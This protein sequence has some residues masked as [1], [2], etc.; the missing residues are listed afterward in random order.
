M[1]PRLFPVFVAPSLKKSRQR[2]F[3]AAAM[4]AV[5]TLAASPFA[6]ALTV[7]WDGGAGGTG[8]DIGT[9][10]NWAGD[11]LPSVVTP[12][13]A[14]WNGTATG[15]LSLVYS[16]AVFAG[17][18]GN[19]GINLN[20]TS[21]QT[22]ALNIDSGANTG[23][24]RMNGLAIAS[25]AGAFSLGNAANV[26]NL[27]L[28]GAAG[29]HT[30]TNGSTN[31]VTIASEVV[32]GLGGGGAHILAV[33]GTGN[34]NFNNPIG[35]GTGTL[36][37][38]KSGTGTA[39]L[40][41]TSPIAAALSVENG[42]VNLS[43]THTTTTAN[44]I[45]VGTVAGQNGLLNVT[46]TLNANKNT[47]PSLGIGT[48]AG[49]RG[50][51]NMTSGAIST[52]SELHI[53]RGT[54]AYAALSM[55][56]GTLTSANWLCVGLNN[57]RAVLNQSGGSISVTTNRMT[58]GAGGVGS[59]GVANLSGG[60]FTNS[61]GIFVGENGTGTLNISGT[62]TATIGD[63][64]FAN[65]ATSLAGTVNLLGGTLNAGSITKGPSSA[66]GVY[67]VNFNG[68]ILKATSTNANFFADLASTS[69]YVRSG[70]ANIDTNGFDVTVTEPLIAPTGNGV[71]APTVTTGGTGYVDT[72]VVTIARGGADT[73]GTGATAVANVTGGVLTSIT[74][75]NRGTGYTDTPVFTLS[76]GGA[77]TEATVT[78]NANTAN[79]GGGLTK[80]GAG[81]LTLDSNSTYPGPTLVSAGTLT[82]GAA[83]TINSSSAI[84]LNGADAKLVKANTLDITQPVIVTQGS[85]DGTGLINSATVA[86]LTQN[87]LN[88]GNGANGTLNFNTL[89]FQGAATVNVVYTA[90]NVTRGFF[91]NN[92]VTNS[93]G[94]VVVNAT[95]INGTWQAGDYPVIQYG[96]SFTGAASHFLVGTVA[97]LSPQ[98][99]ATIA[100]D[101]GSIVL[102]IVGDSLTWTGSQNSNWGTAA[103][104]GS[105]N[106]QYP[107][108]SQNSEF[109]NGNPVL[110]NDSA[111]RFNVNLTSNVSPSTTVFDNNSP[112]D[113]TLSS[114]GNFGIT[115]GSLIK[116]GDGMVT[117]TTTNTYT[118]STTINAGILQLGDGT[119]DGSIATSGVIT[120]NGGKLVFNLIGSHT[121][122]NPLA[123]STS[124]I[125]EKKGGGS[126]TLSGAN[127]FAGDLVLEAGVL[128][129]N[130]PT[131][132]GA[133]TGFLTIQG[134]SINNTSG[135]AVTSTVNKPQK[136]EGD[137]TFTG[138]HDLFL[139]TGAVAVGDTGTSRTI[140]VTANTLGSGGITSPNHRIVKAGAGN[141][142]L[143]GVSTIN[144]IVEIQAGAISSTEDFFAE[145]LAGT[146][147]FENGSA[148][149][150]WSFWTIATDQTSEVLIRNGGGA[151]LLGLIKRGAATWTLTN[152]ANNATGNLVVD[153]GKLILNNTGSYGVAVSATNLNA[154]IGNTADANGVLEINGATVTYNNTSN[155]DLLA[156]RNTLTIANNATG[157]GAVHMSSGSLTT[158]R[159]LSIGSISG[160]YGDYT[161]SGGTASVG[162]FLALGLG[163]GT[164]T[165]NQTGGTF[166]MTTSP[167]TNGAAT[168]SHGEMNIGGSAVF[169]VN[170]T[171]DNGLWVGESGTGILN[172][173][174]SAALNFVATNNG[175]Q[176]GRNATGIGTVNLNGG[177]VTLPRI[178]KGAGAGTLNFNG[179]V[180]AANAA[181]ATF[182]TGLTNAFVYSGGGGINNGGN[183]I[184]IG[185]ALLA[186]AGNGISATGLTVAGTGFIGTPVVQITG[187]GTGATAVANVNSSGALTGITIT[188][189][190]TGYTTAPAFA[191]VGGGIGST[192]TIEG[193]AA[194]VANTGGSMT[195][196]GAGVT[197][198]TAVN[199]YTGNTSVSTGSTLALA[200]NAALRF[201]PG[202]N[203]TTNKVTGAGTA[204]FYGDFNIELGGAA[205]SNGNSWTLVDVTA[206]TFDPLLFTIPGFTQAS[207]VWTKVDGNN[208]WTFTEATGV[209]SL[210]VIGGGG[211]Y[212]SWATANAGGEPAT[213]DFDKDGVENGVEYFMG[214]TGSSFTANPSLINGK[215]TWPKDPAY[216]GTYTVQTSP[217]LV[218]WTDA[219]STVVGNNVEYTPATGGGKVFV[220]LT[221][222]PN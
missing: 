77:T 116:N 73:T 107:S 119:K 186:P 118:G 8:T 115:G 135:A 98:Q 121:Y 141:L 148:N 200:D 171:A 146:G 15:P 60:T 24:L 214:A 202:A 53:G 139:G 26:F 13:T 43:G 172:V 48:I 198:L 182:L 28:G 113:Y 67:E 156:Y 16:N 19:G 203:G 34:W 45:S 193:S 90:T 6:G 111:I 145:G 154:I 3:P 189:P 159:Q 126:L 7:V 99:T 94:K 80:T 88:A 149:T 124:G 215:V 65:N 217:N 170:G 151:G 64:K 210:Q 166:N 37:L 69:A 57:D 109:T 5:I 103:V 82:L 1:K 162:G 96:S 152:N 160:A 49:S 212:A 74:I 105:F 11:A 85:I 195:F 161:Q 179:G 39:N 91:A 72:P 51:V 130:S 104:G 76:G 52:G 122:A 31:A 192:G 183:A 204:F 106:W 185:Q 38:A 58:I 17:A 47:N 216:S 30:W 87:T 81:I 54:G 175:I 46:G 70:G 63:V 142:R 110:F 23:T 168:G 97:G 29:T 138:T 143:S 144:N 140:T 78:A 213:G 42:T 167:V 164:G 120:T 14:E 44:I 221:V 117:I 10:A 18:P 174:G 56:G 108:N 155:A 35:Q 4:A 128:N 137:F 86:N 177:T 134:G 131:A 158:F 150:K 71:T 50:F 9:A 197:T 220:R 41:G 173:S 133:A 93:A 92:L 125:I 219:A 25:G 27:T 21:A 79:T 207:D 157:A 36:T 129:L 2:T 22:E 196:S 55:S 184:T 147:I 199:T 127:T 211:G 222:N 153:T 40:A 190:G 66:N 59:I 20:I 136:W 68:G 12:D 83:A 209:L 84:T 62:A 187:D 163:T 208:T 32:W 205:L 169:N 100:D 95:N 61:V 165:F 123:G 132:L 33:G 188:S 201:V 102:R 206:R 89:T 194:L 181:S 114:T 112:N 178:Y 191:L 218:T 101:G 180:L 176:F 75:T